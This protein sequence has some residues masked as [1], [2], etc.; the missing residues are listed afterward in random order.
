MAMALSEFEVKRHEKALT[1][2]V[3]RNRP[4]PNIRDRVDLSFRVDGKS[5]S[6]E[7]FEVR[8]SVVSSTG[9]TEEPIA[10]AT[11]V[12]KRRVWNVYWQTADL[13]WNAYYPAPEVNT[14][15]EFIALVKEDADACFW[16]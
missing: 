8:R 13:K 5:Q 3:E 9:K 12:E 11:Y 7:I 16:D 2:F 15:D 14:L 10:K 6:V 1:A 4:P